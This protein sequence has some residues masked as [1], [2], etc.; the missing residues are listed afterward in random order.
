MLAIRSWFPKMARGL[1]SKD[2]SFATGLLLALLVWTLSRL[3]DSVVGSATVEYAISTKTV[4]LASG[5]DGTR[6]S[7]ELSNLS[8]DT[9]LRDLEVVVHDPKG[10]TEF[11]VN[12]RDTSCEHPEPAWAADGVCT[13]KKDG[14]FVVFPSLVAGNRVRASIAYSASAA[15]VDRPTVRIRPTTDG[16][17]KLR[18][19]KP[20]FDTWLV[21]H[22]VA[23]L[24]FF[25]VA[26]AVLFVASIAS[27]SEQKR[28]N[29][30]I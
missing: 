7:V 4:K 15:N 12:P 9:A 10:A 30:T 2:H 20:G 11:S 19:M 28:P 3:V 27:T 25:F 13:A 16:D 29:D 6:L 26:V 14:L 17:V 8:R 22:E 21:R 18:L 1:L 5:Q 24:L 23:L